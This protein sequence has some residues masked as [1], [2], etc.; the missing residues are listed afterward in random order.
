MICNIGDITEVHNRMYYLMEYD[1]KSITQ[2]SL[3]W[4]GRKIVL[5]GEFAKNE[6]LLTSIFRED[7]LT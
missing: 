1:E 5:C 3:N 7:V 4:D 6:E 2:L